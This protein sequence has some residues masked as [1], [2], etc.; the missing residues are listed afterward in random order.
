MSTDKIAIEDIDGFI[1]TRQWLESSSGLELIFWLATESGPL[2]LRVSGQEA[3]CFFPSGQRDQVEDALASQGHWRINPTQLKNFDYEDMSA[4]Y[5]TSQRRLFDCRDK[6]AARNIHVAES[7]IKP[8]DRFLMER[9]ITAAA[10]VSGELV[11]REGFSDVLADKIISTEYRPQL[12]AVSIDIETDYAA[13][14]LYSIAIYSDTDSVVFMV[15]PTA[16]EGLDSA[17]EENLELHIYATERAV[18]SAFVE[19]IQLIDPDV[20][21]GWNVV[22]FDLR[23]LQNFCDRLKAPLNIGR[24]REGIV[25]RKAREATDRFYALVPGRAVLDG[26][27][28][29][30]TATYQFENFS[31]EYVSRQLLDRGKLVEDVD[32]RGE[33]ITTLFTTDK[34]A[35]ARY[36]LEDCRLVWDI[37]EKESLVSFAIER[38]LLTGLEIDR[39][40][41]SVAAFDFLYLPR[42][43]RKGFVAPSTDNSRSTNVSPGGHVMASI[44]GIHENVIVL[45]FK[46]LYPS[47]IR[48]FHVDPLAMVVAAQESNP[49]TGYDGGQFSRTEFILPE[50]IASLWAARDQAKADHNAALSQAI[51]IIM[52]SF[53]GILG[54]TGCRFLDSRLVSSITKRGHEILIESKSYI[55]TKG[56]QVIYGDTDSVFVLLG[57]VADKEADGIGN[58][59]VEQL[60][61]WWRERLERDYG[62]ESFLEMEYETHFRK[63]LMP[64]VRGSEAGSKKR[65]AGLVVKDL[66]QQKFHMLFKGLESVRS[67]WSPLAREFQKILYERI[68]FD[69]AYE[70]YIKQTVVDINAGKFENELV[71]RKRIRRKLSD[72]VKN[73][74]PHV[75]AARKAE[76]VRKERDLPSL[77]QFGGWIEYI[78]TINGPEPRQYRQSAIDY[79]F[80]IDKQLAPIVDAILVF[81]SSSMDKILN[82]QIGL[83]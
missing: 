5:F 73:I 27:E 26:I 6:L 53:Y 11:S 24:N 62:I 52:N 43:H 63:F 25:W 32:Q 38:S 78:M 65:Y 31:L 82:K 80:Y 79:D 48:T 28:L 45:D 7:D 35:L 10:K 23:C 42:L 61:A 37:F 17:A 2:R 15:G 66:E 39:Y 56:Y 83:F 76:L 16:K 30:R 57:P 81:K 72:Y 77:Y 33:E 59:L 64:T 1:L 58:K 12:R 36:N 49:I 54:T 67:D 4:L 21:M 44:P 50:L 3:V 20:I 29:M 68:F 22:N 70:D 60:N 75:Q 9:F 8:T 40:G 74:P 18:I 41:G 71:L 69:Q 46:S 34:A 13:N 55:E 47:I 19:R 51:K 14:N